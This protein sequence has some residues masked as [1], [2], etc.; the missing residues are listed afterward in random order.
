MAHM[1]SIVGIVVDPTKVEIVLLSE[2]PK[3]SWSCKHE[4]KVFLLSLGHF[5]DRKV[6]KKY[7]RRKKFS[8]F[9]GGR[10]ERLGRV[11]RRRREEMRESHD[12]R[13]EEPRR[14]E[15]D[16]SKFKIPQF[17]LVTLEFGKYALLWWTQMLDD[18]RRRVRDPCEHWVVL[19]RFIR[20]I[21]APPY[22]R[23]LHNKLQG[24]Y[25]GSWSV[26]EYHKEMEK[27]VIMAQILH[28]LNKEIQDVVGLH[29]YGTLDIVVKILSKSLHFSKFYSHHT[30]Q[31]RKFEK[32]GNLQSKKPPKLQL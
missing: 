2:H 17:L 24:L 10:H 22:I 12:R 32:S 31:E 18:I 29:H 25:Q 23:Y 26:E 11:E 19:K 20:G 7:E 3:T 27:D 13:G 21:F 15:I 30:K 16:I 28:G 1:I 5:G 14:E 6:R 4:Y 9:H 8:V